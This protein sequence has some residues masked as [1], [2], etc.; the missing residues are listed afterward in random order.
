MGA[1]VAE[2]QW[3]LTAKPTEQGSSDG[4]YSASPKKSPEV[5]WQ[6]FQNGWEFKFNQILHAYYAF[7]P[8]LDYEFLF[9][10]LQL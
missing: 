3:G 8:V 1:E 9:N 2:P 5:S 7:L 6:F 10:Y 4:V